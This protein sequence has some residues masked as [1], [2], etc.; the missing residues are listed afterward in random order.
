MQEESSSDYVDITEGMSDIAKTI[1]IIFYAPAACW[2]IYS[3]FKE[4]FPKLIWVGIKE[5]ITGPAEKKVVTNNILLD[6]G[7]KEIGET[8]FVETYRVSR[9]GS[10]NQSSRK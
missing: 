6:K 7:L 5:L 4:Q 2:C 8:Y 10:F 1:F 3:F 9:Q